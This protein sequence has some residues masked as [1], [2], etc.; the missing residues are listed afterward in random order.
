MYV[1][2]NQ[3]SFA[4]TP[5]NQS[6]A[7][8]RAD[9]ADALRRE[10]KRRTV[11]ALLMA[12]EAGRPVGPTAQEGLN[13]VARPA[14]GR[15]E[16]METDEVSA[17]DTRVPETQDAAFAQRLEETLESFPSRDP[18]M[19][20]VPPLGVSLLPRHCPFDPF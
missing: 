1:K 18:E 6:V 2:G 15:G 7:R 8:K 14:A 4:K 9:E 11:D 10:E 17:M 19:R 12:A 5:D 16:R 20:Q 13:G 3:L